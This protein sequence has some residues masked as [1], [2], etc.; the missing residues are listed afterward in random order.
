MNEMGGIKDD[1]IVTKVNEDHYYV[2]FNAACKEK[3]LNH[4]RVY[5]HRKFK[6]LKIEHHSE[7]L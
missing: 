4:C 3:A 6:D 5:W 7:L 1:C 2:V